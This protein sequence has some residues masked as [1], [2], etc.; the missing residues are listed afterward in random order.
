M[1]GLSRSGQL[2]FLRAELTWLPESEARAIF[3]RD[4]RRLRFWQ[5]GLELD[6]EQFHEIEATYAGDSTPAS[7]WLATRVS[8]AERIFIIFSKREVCTMSVTSFLQH[9][10]RMFGPGRDDVLITNGQESWFLFYY[11]EDE[12][13]FGRTK[14][15]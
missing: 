4:N 5:S 11:H 14:C 2:D 1:S 8:E 9:W 10:H 12:L 3:E 6:P 13:H 15:G 7:K